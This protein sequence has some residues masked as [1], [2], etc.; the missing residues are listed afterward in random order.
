MV[1]TGWTCFDSRVDGNR[2]Y[3]FWACVACLPLLLPS[4]WCWWNGGEGRSQ[5]SGD[6]DARTVQLVV[7]CLSFAL[8]QYEV[9]HTF[10]HEG[11][12]KRVQGTLESF[13]AFRLMKHRHTLH[14]LGGRR[15]LCYNI[16]WPFGDMLF[17]T[18]EPQGK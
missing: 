10:H 4:V 14:H 18:L 3:G 9:L 5:A 11:L 1:L 2:V 8:L 12:P 16:T 7:S 17:G 6:G 13:S 15:G